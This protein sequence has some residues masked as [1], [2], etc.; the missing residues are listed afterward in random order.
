MQGV[1]ARQI[2]LI[3]IC[4]SSHQGDGAL[5]VPIC[6]SVVQRRSAKQNRTHQVTPKFSSYLQPF[7]TAYLP[8]LSFI[9]SSAP[10]LNSKLTHSTFLQNKKNKDFNW[11]PS[12]SQVQCI[13]HKYFWSL[14]FKLIFCWFI[15]AS[16]LMTRKTTQQIIGITIF[17]IV[18][19]SF[20]IRSVSLTDLCV[21]AEQHRKFTTL[22]CSEIY[23]ATDD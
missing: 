21:V 17:T 2:Q 16:N 8:K 20:D 5:A 9:S 7:R 19:P 3:D 22:L 15:S 4:T 11:E 6:C 18:L 13:T 12:V 23:T 1:A 14:S 10:L